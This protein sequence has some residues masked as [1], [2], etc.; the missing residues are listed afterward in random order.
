ML[1]VYGDLE[2]PP[3]YRLESRARPGLTTGGALTLVASYAVG[4]GF[5]L[6]QGLDDGNGWLLVPLV[7]PWGAIAQREL[8]CKVD[9]SIDP[10]QA[11][12]EVNDCQSQT[13]DQV[14]E[15]SILAAVGLGQAIGTTLLL[16]GVLDRENRWVRDDLAGAQVDVH[17]LPGG[18]AA[19]VSGRF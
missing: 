1:S 18:G 5:G 15:I 9:A 2:P 3:G 6:N 13:F 12:S 14:Q 11:A 17:P 16:I 19:T 4:L 10:D 8:G 7:G